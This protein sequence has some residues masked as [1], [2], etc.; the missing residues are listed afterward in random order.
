[1]LIVF[2]Y[3]NFCEKYKGRKTHLYV[4]LDNFLRQIDFLK[5]RFNNFIFLKDYVLLYEK[6]KDEVFVTITVDDGIDSFNLVYDYFKD[7]N[8]KVNL[9]VSSGKIGIEEYSRDLNK[10]IKYLTKKELISF[11]SDIVD[12]QN[13]G[14]SHSDLNKINAKEY[15]KELMY[16]KKSIECMINKKINIFCFPYGGYSSQIIELLKD[17]NYLGACTCTSGVNKTFNPFEIKRIPI[18]SHDNE[19]DLETKI[20]T[21]E[22]EK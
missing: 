22:N 10:N 2:A 9:F 7:N 4:G 16:S 19:D 1:M 6:I 17:Y 21:Y 12:I 13:H 11:D 14:A 5:Q 18:S 15:M 8:L 3:H 20:F